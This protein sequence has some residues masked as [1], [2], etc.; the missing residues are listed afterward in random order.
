MVLRTIA[1][2][3]MHQLKLVFK[4]LKDRNKVIFVVAAKLKYYI[5]I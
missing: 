3:S 5:Y 2:K 1:L 4:L